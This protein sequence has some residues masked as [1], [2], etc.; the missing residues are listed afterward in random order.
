MCDTQTVTGLGLLV[1]GF[2]DLFNGITAYHF[3]LVVQLAWFSNITHLTGLTVLRH[4]LYHHPVKKWG[5]LFFTIVLSI[6]LLT[7]MAPTLFFNWAYFGKLFRYTYPDYRALEHGLGGSASLPGSYALCFFNVSRN[8]EWHYATNRF[9]WTYRDTPA[10]GSGIT[11]MVLVVLNLAFRAI[12]LQHSFDEAVRHV[13]RKSSNTW[14]GLIVNVSRTNSRA[15]GVRAMLLRR[16]VLYI[17]VT[18]LLEVRL[19]FDLLIS[20]LSDVS[21]TFPLVF[22]PHLPPLAQPIIGS[23]TL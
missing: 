13:R 22:F 1:S 19:F 15:A 2:A 20:T 12:K 7:A 4:H 23:K 21:L 16:V 6:M 3:L 9:A 18:T 11:S 14:K 8:I 17:G 10:F 5:R